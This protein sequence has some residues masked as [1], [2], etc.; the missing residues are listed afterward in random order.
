MLISLIPIIHLVI[1][2][3]M[4]VAP[5]KFFPE[6]GL[7]QLPLWTMI[8]TITTISIAIILGELM[9]VLI[10]QSG[11]MITQKKRYLFSF[12]IAVIELGITPFGIVLGIF[13]ILYLQKDS[14]RKSYGIENKNNSKVNLD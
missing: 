2:T 9:G 6:S 8:I 3:S 4:V 13:T 5:D 10:I 11:R 14:V 12:I 1:F 7:D